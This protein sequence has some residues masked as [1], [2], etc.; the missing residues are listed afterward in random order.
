MTCAASASS[1]SASASSAR[2]RALVGPRRTVGSM[3]ASASAS[4]SSA[5]AAS[6]V[7]HVRDVDDQRVGVAGQRRTLRQPEVAGMDLG[8]GRAGPR[9]IPRSAV[10]MCVASASIA[11]VFWSTTTSVS[12]AASPSTCRDT[13]TVTFSP[14]RT[15]HEVDVLDGVLD[16][17]ALNL[18]RQR[19]LGRAVHVDRQQGVRG[20]QRQQRLVTRQ[21]DVDRD[22][23][24]GRTRRREPC[25][26]DGSGGQRP[27]RTRYAIRR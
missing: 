18:L 20:A 26:R 2:T 4:A 8:A 25:R 21:G 24:R 1:D 16:R 13:S 3:P 22:R 10:G 14:R 19:E 7:W 17:V 5:S 9:W 11:M 23:C 6:A 15:M 12:G 27:C